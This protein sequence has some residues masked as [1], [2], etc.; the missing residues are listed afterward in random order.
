MSKQDD[1]LRFSYDNVSVEI[2]YADDPYRNC[3]TTT[4]LTPF[5]LGMFDDKINRRVKLNA[6]DIDVG[7]SRETIN[8]GIWLFGSIKINGMLNY[9]RNR[10][11]YV[12][13]EPLVFMLSPESSNWIFRHGLTC[14]VIAS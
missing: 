7:V 9:H 6:T 11:L 10:Q 8:F 3:L 5:P 2:N 12:Y 13:C 1:W 14:K 4:L